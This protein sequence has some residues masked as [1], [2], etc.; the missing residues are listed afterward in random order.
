MKLL[1]QR[2]G[3]YKGTI[4]AT[5]KDAIQ[6]AKSMKKRLCEHKRTV[7]AKGQVAIQMAKRRV[8]RAVSR[9]YAL[10]CHRLSWARYH[11][12]VWQVRHKG[13]ATS[14]TI[15]LFLCASGYWYPVLQS[16][17]DTYFLDTQRLAALRALLLTLGGALIGASVI[18]FSLVMFAMQINVARMPHGLF[19]KFS[20]DTRIMTA[21]IGTFLLAISVACTS[22]IP[23]TSWVTIAILVATWGTTLI[24]G[25]FLYA[26]R[27]ALL[28]INP[29]KQ[30]D[31]VAEDARGKCELGF[32]EQNEP[33][34]CSKKQILPP[35]LET[36][37]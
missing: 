30:L 8:V 7:L 10:L 31:F 15:I 32:G 26:Y 9:S 22:L 14:A 21:C 23:D 6:M 2:L 27:R 17:L 12:S 11:L 28:L 13:A 33:R 19:R 16:V 3:K 37:C 25:L 18:T 29:S 1:F 36:N 34:R 35:M 4:L 20:V 24:V 5:G